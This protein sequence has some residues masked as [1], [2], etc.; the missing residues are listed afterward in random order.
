V[1]TGID[2]PPTPQNIQFTSVPT[3]TGGHFTTPGSGPW[4]G[5]TIPA[6][7][8]LYLHTFS[9]LTLHPTPYEIWTGL[10]VH[11]VPG[12]GGGASRS[13]ATFS[14]LARWTG[15]GTLPIAGAYG[16]ADLS[17]S[18]VNYSVTRLSDI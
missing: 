7:G 17:G 3:N 11:L 12:N 5:P 14:Y 9:I 4:P 15:S 1:G 10:S 2:S 16:P 18:A 6:G 13:T 8:G